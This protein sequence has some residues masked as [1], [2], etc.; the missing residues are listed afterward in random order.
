MTQ[1]TDR[2]VRKTKAQLRAALSALM[3]EK[4]IKDITVRE[5]TERADLNRGTF[6]C[7]Y[8]DIYDMV[9]QVQTEMLE[10]LNGVLNAYTPT[11]LRRGLRPILT[12]VFLLVDRNADLF[13]ALLGSR[14]SGPMARLSRIV[15]EKVLRD[16]WS[17][18]GGAIPGG[19]YYLDFAV[20]G[21][22]GLV[23]RWL[24]TGRREPPEEMACLTERVLVSG[25]GPIGGIQHGTD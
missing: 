16:W 22:L 21:I 7:H 2:R 9:E 18:F 6:Y 5:L 3:Q 17:E 12:D 8:K 13:T 4:E 23:G 10:E 1:G 20:A 11:E 15:Y 24:N 19:E 14:D 25:V